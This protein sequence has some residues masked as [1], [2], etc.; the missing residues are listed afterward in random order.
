MAVPRAAV[1]WGTA[2]GSNLDTHHRIAKDV[3]DN[4]IDATTYP[5]LVRFKDK[6]EDGSNTESHDL[7]DDNNTQW[8][9][10]GVGPAPETWFYA[11]VQSDGQEGALS[12]YKKYSFEDAYK[13][14][15]FELHCAQDKFVPA[16]IRRCCHGTRGVY[17]LDDMEY[18]AYLFTF[19]YASSSSPWIYSFAH[20]GGTSTFEYWLNDSMDDDDRDDIGSDADDEVDAGGT[21]IVDG[22]SAWGVPNT[23]WGTYGQP[24]C[25]LNVDDIP[26]LLEMLPGRNEG[27]DYYGDISGNAILTREQLKKSY[28]DTL[29]RIRAHSAE[30]PPMVPD[31]DTHGRP[32][33]SAKIFGP[34]KPV[35]VTF[36]AMENRLKTVIGSMLVGATAIKDTTG[37]VWDGGST[38]THDL[39]ADSSV[40]SLP[41]KDTIAVSWKGDL[42]A[43]I[44]ADGNHTF[45]MKV[46][47]Q[48]GNDSEERTRSVKYDKTKPT[49]AITVNVLP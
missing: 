6:L 2:L 27:L 33:I 34:N 47:D 19:G 21:L 29:A 18:W 35:D 10:N 41:W 16:H 37:K 48:D 36:V 24:P 12:L 44:L 43:G 4:D 22:P 25:Y 15:G 46:K 39:A 42:G 45:K 1:A 9:G 40:S 13:E 20:P 30:L 31:D 7:P 32:S 3:V 26:V 14:M 8:W 5:D 11:D 38:A 49:G 17:L 28:D 23:D